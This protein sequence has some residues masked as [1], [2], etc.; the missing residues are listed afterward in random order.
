MPTYCE[1]GL[2]E[3]WVEYDTGESRRMIPLHTLYT[4]IGKSF[5]GIVTWRTIIILSDNDATS[6]IGTR[7]TGLQ[8]EPVKYLLALG[9]H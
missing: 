9:E 1:N 3:F 7:K 5:N 2:E 8:S 6:K 4:N